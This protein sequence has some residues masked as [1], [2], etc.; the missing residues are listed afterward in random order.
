[1]DK[2]RPGKQ[3]QADYNS[4]HP[5]PIEHFSQQERED[6]MVDDGENVQILKVIMADLPPALTA[7][8]ICKAVKEDKV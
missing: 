7:E 4:W 5:Q 3:M 6:H 2:Y 8:M 1:M